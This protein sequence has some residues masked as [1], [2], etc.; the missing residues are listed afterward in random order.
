MKTHPYL[1]A[2]MAGIAVPTILL[3]VAMSVFLVVRIVYKIPVPIERI[4]VFP[5]A[6][7]P[8]LFGLWNMF[9]VWLRPR[10]HLPIGFHGALL[11]FIIVPVALTIATSLGFLAVTSQGLVL[12]QAVTI[13]YSFA[14]VGFLCGLIIYYLVWKHLVGFF[15]EL[16]GIA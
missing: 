7:V 11:P 12:F 16:L 10:R 9:Y 13:H 14:G 6:L 2:Y 8:N 15:N 3:L 4:L 5:M 1:R